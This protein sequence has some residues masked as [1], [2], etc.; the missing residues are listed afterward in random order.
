MIYIVKC[1]NCGQELEHQKGVKNVSVKVEGHK[2]V[3]IKVKNPYYC[4]HCKEF[5]LKT[6][7]IK[8]GVY[9]LRKRDD[10]NVTKN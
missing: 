3:T 6:H 8:K 1:A 4:R 5:Y 10:T 7:E 9:E 2:N